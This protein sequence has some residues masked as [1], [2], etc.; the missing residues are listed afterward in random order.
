MI[1]E[2]ATVTGVCGD[3]ATVTSMIK[4]S[5]HS[6]AQ[7][8]SCGSG[9]IAKALPHKSLVIELTTK[10]K[11]KVGD[12]VIIALPEHEL[13]T[14]ALQ[15]YLLPLMG[16]II[17]ALLGQYFISLSVINHELWL[18]ALSFLGGYLGFSLAK[19]LQRRKLSCSKDKRW[20]NPQIVK[21][22]GAKIPVETS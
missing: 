8:D 1:E 14:S 7:A 18:V 6:C 21:V 17:F 12:Q 9:Q 4:S 15:V 10:T 19:Y 22:I 3:K 16:L 11:L 5:C 13:L 20:L 2:L